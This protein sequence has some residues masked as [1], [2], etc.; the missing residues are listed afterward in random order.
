MD[1]LNR[2]TASFM[3][4]ERGKKMVK[5]VKQPVGRPRKRPLD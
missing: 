2:V 3:S 5:W 4:T 1:Y